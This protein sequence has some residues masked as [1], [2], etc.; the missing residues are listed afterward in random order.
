MNSPGEEP[1]FGSKTMIHLCIAMGCIMIAF[2]ACLA[3]LLLSNKDPLTLFAGVATAITGNS[4]QATVRN[5]L[6]DGSARQS[7]A[8]G[9]SQPS[10]PSTASLGPSVAQ[11]FV[12]P[13]S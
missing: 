13:S 3:V 1:F 9:Y 2:A 5:T 8:Q 7:Y 4:V 6:V 10:A 11:P 12:R